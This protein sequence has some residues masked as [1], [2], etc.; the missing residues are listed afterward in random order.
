VPGQREGGAECQ[1]VTP[2]Q[3]GRVVWYLAEKEFS[4]VGM[5]ESTLGRQECAVL[6]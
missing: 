3:L 5:L 1:T 6:Q 2:K 4:K